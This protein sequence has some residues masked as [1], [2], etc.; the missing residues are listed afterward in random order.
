MPVK[1]VHT[2]MYESFETT[3]L[4]AGGV[5]YVT[6]PVVDRHMKIMA[7]D[8]A[9]GDVAVVDRPYALGPFKIC[10]GPNNRGAALGYGNLYVATLD[11]KL[12]RVRR[13]HRCASAGRRASPIR[14]SATPRAWRRRSTTAR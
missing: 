13:A 3:P 10:C 6:T 9:T 12:R 14:R 8:A 11:A 7:L 2:G 1:I 4:V 5:M